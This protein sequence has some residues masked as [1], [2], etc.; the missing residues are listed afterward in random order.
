[1]SFDQRV[2]DVHSAP[3][4]HMDNHRDIPLSLGRAQQVL[5]NDR[6]SDFSEIDV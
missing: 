5:N 1:M 3:S 4:T 6:E 2:I